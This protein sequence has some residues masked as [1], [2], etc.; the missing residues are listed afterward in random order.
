MRLEKKTSNLLTHR[1]DAICLIAVAFKM[2]KG[3]EKG[4]ISNPMLWPAFVVGHSVRMNLK[5]C[6]G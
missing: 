5:C 3:Q 1:Y 4:V 6:A 2:R